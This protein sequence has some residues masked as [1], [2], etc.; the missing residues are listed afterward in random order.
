MPNIRRLIIKHAMYSA[1]VMLASHSESNRAPAILGTPSL[2][3]VSDI[4]FQQAELC[5]ILSGEM[6]AQASLQAE[7]LVC[8]VANVPHG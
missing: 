6:L 5:H 7:I 2:G 4:K 8:A 3:L 1:H